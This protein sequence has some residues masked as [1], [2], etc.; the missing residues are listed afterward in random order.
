MGGKLTLAFFAEG[1][2]GGSYS[3]YHE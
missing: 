2:P 3:R 1:E